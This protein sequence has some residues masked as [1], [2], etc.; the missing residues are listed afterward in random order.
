MVNNGRPKKSQILRGLPPQLAM[1]ISND[2]RF[3][4]SNVPTHQGPMSAWAHMPGTPP[5][6]C[7][8]E[9]HDLRERWLAY[10]SATKKSPAFG[11]KSLARNQSNQSKPVDSVDS[12]DRIWWFLMYK[13]QDSLEKSQMSPFLIKLKSQ[14][15]RP[16][17]LD[18]G[19]FTAPMTGRWWWKFGYK[20]DQSW[21]YT[22]KMVLKKS[23]MFW[24]KP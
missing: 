23:K 5:I 24:G 15:P 3:L 18:R 11:F 4:L 9:F 8:S 16:L 1:R 21:F 20:V 10:T 13:N 2:S 14:S 12:K 22:M 17:R 6:E 7:P 19:I